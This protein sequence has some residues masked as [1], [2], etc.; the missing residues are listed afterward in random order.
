MK[1]TLLCCLMAMP[2]MGLNA[3]QC[4]IEGELT[5]DSLRF[6]EKKVSQVYLTAL[7]EYDNFQAIDSVKV[8]NGKFRFTRQLDP[9]DPILLYFI[10]GFDNGAA[11]F[12]LEP[13]T[14]HLRFDAA[15][16]SGCVATGTPNNELMREYDAIKKKCVAEQTDSA[17]I[18]KARYGDDFMAVPEGNAAWLRLGAEALMVAY[19]EQLQ[20]LARHYDSP[21]APLMMDRELY[22]LYNKKMAMRMVRSISPKLKK[23]PYYVSLLNNVRAME[24]KVGDELPDIKLPMSDGTQK[25]LSDYQ[26]KI[27]LLDFW[28]SW[29]APCLKQMPKLKELY[30]E[31]KDNNFAIIS[32]SLD[33]IEDAWRGAISRLDIEKPNWLHVSDLKAWKSPAAVLMGVTEI[34]RTI[35]VSP[36]GRA[37]AFNL[38]GDELIQK[39]E[40][41]LMEEELKK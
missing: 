34:P 4:I 30:E 9:N 26:G 40:Q 17:R 19:G 36:D 1:K 31:N 27:V 8:K 20:F 24:L 18:L 15:F 35:L 14:V 11:H 25:F 23:H 12:F 38:R 13:G 2:L 21:L 41:I 32:Y 3:Q 5:K 16:P 28:A 29:C 22:Y 33:N 6:E 10:T 37:I 39:V 7:D